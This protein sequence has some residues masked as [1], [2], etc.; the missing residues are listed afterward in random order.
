MLFIA[1]VLFGSSAL[2]DSCQRYRDI[3][4]TLRFAL[5]MG[6]YG[7][8]LANGDRQGL[9]QMSQ[10][11]AFTGVATGVFKV[12]GEKARPDAGTS[13]QS[14]VSGHVSAAMAGAAF[15]NTRYGRKW[16]IPAY[17]LA[18]LTAYSRVCAQKHFA[19]DVLGGTMV[20]VMANWYATSPHPDTARLYPSFSSNGLEVAV[21]SFFGGNRQPLAPS[22]FKSRF[23]VVFEFGPLTQ[24]TNLV[25]APNGQGDVVDLADLEIGQTTSTARLLYEYFPRFS[26]RQDFSLYFSPL[27]ITDF[28][29][30]TEAFEFAGVD[31]DPALSPDFN[32]NYRW[33]DLRARWRYAVI[34][35]ERVKLTLGAGVQY[36][37]TEVEIEQTVDGMI[38]RSAYIGES[39][40]FPIAHVGMS[41]GLAPRWSLHL[42]I[43]GM[44]DFVASSDRGHY[45]YSGLEIRFE[46]SPIW[47][48]TLGARKIDGVLQDDDSFNDFASKDI[49]LQIGRSF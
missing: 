25:Q 1:L 48:V 33:F 26:D 43:D 6:A 20:A 46:A 31:F 35:R 28:G 14:F 32:T 38:A 44:S 42:G 19:D 13:R 23:R 21:S 34:D 45:W 17:L 7:L 3:G 8:A 18:G 49:N 15:V 9:L 22:E 30:P 4:D 39:A 10:T 12:F 27:G 16:G 29:N 24:S 36:T 5:P 40:I 47:D 2:A 37:D 41:I 11:L